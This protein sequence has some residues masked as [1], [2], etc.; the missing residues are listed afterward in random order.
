MSDFLTFLT[1]VGI[2][3]GLI[4]AIGAQNAFVLK[5]GITKSHIFI[6]AITCSVIDA[7]LII[8]GI[9]G[10]GDFISE[11]EQL[12]QITKYGG[13][14]FLF[15]YGARSFYSSIYL[16]HSLAD[17]AQSKAGDL[18]KTILTLLALS[19]LNPHVYLDTIVLLGSIGAQMEE[20][21]RLYFALG[22]VCAS[23]MWFF[24]LAYGAGHLSRFFKS[25]ASWKILDAC[26]G[27]IMWSIAVSL[28]V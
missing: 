20:G 7:V 17:E 25:S 10:L 24:S 5:K 11:N 18:K 1:G 19:L 21:E 3:A 4:I 8:F 22:A 9:C 12:L 23:F 2:G 14:V 13:A 15:Y 26:I 6:V 28:F 16:T 27:V